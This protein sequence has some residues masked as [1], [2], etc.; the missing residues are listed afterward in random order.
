VS[1]GVRVPLAL[2]VTAPQSGQT[3]SASAL[4]VTWSDSLGAEQDVT[5]WVSGYD[6]GT[7]TSVSI[8]CHLRDDGSHT[9]PAG[10]MAQLPDGSVSVSLYR[11]NFESYEISADEQIVLTGSAG[12]YTNVTKQ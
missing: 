11:Y 1:D 10:L 5:L 2:S 8:Q 4:P 12:F 9:V 3:I 6:A 7:M